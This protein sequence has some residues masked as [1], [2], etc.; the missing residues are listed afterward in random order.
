M[1]AGGSGNVEAVDYVAW[2]SLKSANLNRDD[3]ITADLSS[4]N[5]ATA[6]ILKKL[7][8]AS[9]GFSPLISTS[10]DSMEIPVDKVQ[11]PLPDVAGL[12]DNFQPSGEKL[13]LAAHVTGPAGTAFPDGPPPAAE[14][15]E[16]NG[17]DKKDAKSAKDAASAAPPPA[18]EPQKNEPQIKTAASPINIVVV[19]DTDFAR[20]PLLGRCAGFLR[21]A[22]RRGQRQ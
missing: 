18:A 14:S 16:N 6:G 11:G 10:A 22:R 21:P 7:P 3:L 1:N 19:A 9:T 15:P 2:L 17:P 13:V 4:I 5:M 8:G 12:L 20:R